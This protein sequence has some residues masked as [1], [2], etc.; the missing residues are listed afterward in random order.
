MNWIITSSIIS[1]KETLSNESNI[2]KSLKAKQDSTDHS[3][4]QDS[5]SNYKTSKNDKNHVKEEVQ[6]LSLRMWT[7]VRHNWFLFF[8][9]FPLQLHIC[10]HHL[11]QGLMSQMAIFF[12]KLFLHGSYKDRSHTLGFFWCVQHDQ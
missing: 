11:E 9:L 2:Q 3:S 6:R 1:S 8:Y 12:I 7:K 10:N 5:K 4:N